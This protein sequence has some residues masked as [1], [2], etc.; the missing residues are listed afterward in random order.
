MSL[1]KPKERE[2]HFKVM[3]HAFFKESKQSKEIRGR[4]EQNR[5]V[6]SEMDI[7]K[8]AEPNPGKL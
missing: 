5:V 8:G 6:R 3:I 2:T 7:R 4:E 1:G